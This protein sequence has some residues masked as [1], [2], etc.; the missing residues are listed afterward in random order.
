MS[1]ENS[2]FVNQLDTNY[3]PSDSE[4]LEIRS[5]LLEPTDELARIDARIE[6][7]EIALEQLKEQRAS[8]EAP[9][10][11]H[12]ALISPMRRIP[13]DVL[14]EIFC[15]CLPSEHNAVV[16]PAEAPLVLGRIC[17]HWRSVAYSSPI[18]WS[19]I[20]I[21]SPHHRF[22]PPKI[23]LR[24]EKIVEEWLKRSATCPLS[25]S[26]CDYH[27]VVAPDHFDQHPFVRQ[28][29]PFS[30]RLRHLALTGDPELLHPLLRL[31]SE[32][33]PLLQSLAM[34]YRGPFPDIPN[35]FHLPTL[36]DVAICIMA[37][38]PPRS[39]PLRWSQLTKL[40]L[41]CE[42]L[43][44]EGGL[45]LSE[46]FNVL[47]MC[48]ILVD[49]EIRVTLDSGDA[50][51]ILDTSP[52]L[53]PHL[54]HLVLKGWHILFQKWISH[55]VVPNLRSLRVGETFG[56]DMA[57]SLP[58]DGSLSVTIDSQH[59]T[60]SSVDQLFRSFP[61]ISHLR[62]SS[63]APGGVSVD[64]GFL[65]FL[66]S[67]HNPCLALTNITILGWNLNVSDAALLAFVKAR[68]VMPTHLQ[69]IRID[70]HRPMELDIMPELQSFIEDGLEVDIEYLLPLWQFSA[71][72]GLRV[73]HQG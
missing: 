6:E 71:R 13:H 73:D 10:D 31:G 33:L 25:I 53:L 26:L 43:G 48:P 61:L 57:T 42:P 68:M 50:D 32:D 14:L 62:L 19:T 9:I 29:L 24:L 11:A 36:K 56:R 44:A 30:Q 45:D 5:L 67:P 16:D 47:R 17:K 40:H 55:L 22:I 59:F 70:L 18:L 58:R 34:E 7:M 12:R 46:A 38:V 35:A 3:V 27:N 51:V 39:L 28:L 52:I 60:Q 37:P 49:C 1:L 2:P 69:Q 65:A 20:H 4:V 54:R 63:V 21:P 8:F 41:E 15:A 64:D 66:G 72:E 23:L